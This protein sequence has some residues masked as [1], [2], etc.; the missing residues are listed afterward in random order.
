MSSVVVVVVTVALL[1]VAPQQ[2][3]T[4]THINRHTSKA[5]EKLT[6]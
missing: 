5:Y 2:T 4:H 6:N 1:G 3:P